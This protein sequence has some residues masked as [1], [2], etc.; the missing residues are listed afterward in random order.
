[1]FCRCRALNILIVTGM[2]FLLSGTRILCDMGSSLSTD[3][4]CSEAEEHGHDKA[5][6]QDVADNQ[7]S[8]HH[9]D[10]VP[11]NAPADSNPGHCCSNWY[12]FTAESANSSLTATTSSSTLPA[13]IEFSILSKSTSSPLNETIKR[14][15]STA[16]NRAPDCPLYLT[17]HSYRV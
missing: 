15:T 4:C 7:G 16:N 9:E 10:T 3:Q 8:T 1:M 6:T 12:I 11:E 14:Y 13:N 17:L 2:L 5:S